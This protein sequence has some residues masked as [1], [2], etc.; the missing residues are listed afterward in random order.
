MTPWLCMQLAAQSIWSSTIMMTW[1]ASMENK[2]LWPDASCPYAQVASFP[3]DYSHHFFCLDKRSGVRG[4]SSIA[5]QFRAFP[6]VLY[7]GCCLI[8]STGRLVAHS[9]CLAIVECGS[10]EKVVNALSAW[11]AFETSQPVLRDKCRLVAVFGCYCLSQA[12]FSLP[13]VGTPSC[14]IYFAFGPTIFGTSFLS[15]HLRLLAYRLEPM[16]S[17]CACSF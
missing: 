1:F 10:Q 16:E 3:R 8:C 11:G 6:P 9:F 2:K 5:K 4:V 14:F 12:C 15:E 7:S 17:S 13:Q